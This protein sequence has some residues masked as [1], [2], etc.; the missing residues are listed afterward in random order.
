MGVPVWTL[1]RHTTNIGYQTITSTIPDYLNQALE[2]ISRSCD[3]HHLP[4]R[5]F[6]H[7]RRTKVWTSTPHSMVTRHLPIRPNA[8]T[9]WLAGDFKSPVGCTDVDPSKFWWNSLGKKRIDGIT[10]LRR[11]DWTLFA[12]A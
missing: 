11:H 8:D 9:V 7:N 5:N 4:S 2:E 12:K 10:T 6:D 1:T 3:A